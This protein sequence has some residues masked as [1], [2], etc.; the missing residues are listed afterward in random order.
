MQPVNCK[1]LCLSPHRSTRSDSTHLCPL[2]M[3]RLRCSRLRTCSRQAAPPPPPAR[4]MLL[5]LL[6]HLLAFQLAPASL[7][8]MPGKRN[9]FSTRPW[10]QFRYLRPP[11]VQRLL[12]IRWALPLTRT[13]ATT[14]PEPNRLSSE[15]K[16]PRSGSPCS[17][18]VSQGST[19]RSHSRKGNYCC[20]AW[21]R[22]R[23]P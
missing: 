11:R 15:L 22:K 5:Q 18:H 16:D 19:S 9:L 6:L 23:L 13:C 8:S 12:L 1:C 3:L 14:S 10:P 7:C 2:L 4:F 17:S 20:Q 21:M